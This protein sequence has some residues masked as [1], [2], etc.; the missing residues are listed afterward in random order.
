MLD[1]QQGQEPEKKEKKKPKQDNAGSDVMGT[2]FKDLADIKDH[3]ASI[4]N[5]ISDIK[6]IHDKALNNVITEQQ[7]AGV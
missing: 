1:L 6:T 5:S 4:K 3:I 2:F 7:N